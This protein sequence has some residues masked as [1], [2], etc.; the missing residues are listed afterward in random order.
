M[1]AKKGLFIQSTKIFFQ[2]S[3]TELF[4]NVSKKE[5]KLARVELEPIHLR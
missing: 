4:L 1:D 2:V 3:L 5:K